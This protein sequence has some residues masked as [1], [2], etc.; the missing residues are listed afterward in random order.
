VSSIELRDC[1]IELDQAMFM[2]CEQIK[3]VQCDIKIVRV[4][5][6]TKIIM[7]TCTKLSLHNCSKI[8]ILDFKSLKSLDSIDYVEDKSENL[9]TF[10]Y[11][12]RLIP[13]VRVVQIDVPHLTMETF[14]G[15]LTNAVL[16]A[17]AKQLLVFTVNVFE[18]K[19]SKLTRSDNYPGI[20]KSV[21]K[22]FYHIESYVHT[23]GEIKMAYYLTPLQENYV[24]EVQLRIR[25][26]I[27]HAF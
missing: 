19:C 26:G 10:Y 1:S 23:K 15:F 18:M 7:P 12:L 13:S 14:A 17:T 2:R 4:I 5:A 8:D 3:L 11:Q 27:M 22:D 9:L 16:M 21:L 6:D 24:Q 20:H 25:K